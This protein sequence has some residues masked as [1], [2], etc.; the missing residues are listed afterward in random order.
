M[1]RLHSYVALPL[2]ARATLRLTYDPRCS[3]RHSRTSPARLRAAKILPLINPILVAH[4]SPPPTEVSPYTLR[5]RASRPASH[6]LTGSTPDNRLPL[7]PLNDKPL[8]LDAPP[9]LPLD[10][11]QP[12]LLD[13]PQLG[14]DVRVCLARAPEAVD[15]LLG[16]GE[17]ELRGRQRRLGEVE[18][19]RQADDERLEEVGLRAE[20]LE[21]GECPPVLDALGVCVARWCAVWKRREEE[22]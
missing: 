20:L 14:H 9:A 5:H 11:L 8:P 2:L 17:L 4:I 3:S 7:L 18:L 22:G 16:C 12:V 15:L 6:R 19:G 21:G 10:L 1:D 13:A